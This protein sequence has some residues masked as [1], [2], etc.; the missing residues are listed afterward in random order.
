MSRVLEKLWY[1]GGKPSWPWRSLLSVGEQLYGAGVAARNGL[2]DRGWMPAARPQGTH[3]VSVGNLHAGGMGKTPVVWFLASLLSAQ[4]RKV[5]ILTRGYGRASKDDQVFDAR[6]LP[7]VERVGDEPRLLAQRLPDARIYV[8]ADRRALAFRAQEEGAEVLLLDDGFQHRRLGRD[9][10][11][12]VADEAVGFGQGALLPKGPLREPVHALKRA[13]LVWW[14]AAEGEPAELPQGI[15]LPMVRARR[16]VD[17]LLSPHGA[18]EPPVALAGQA[19]WLVAGI[20]R[21]ERFERTVR[22][23][24]ADVRGTSWF[25]DHHHFSTAELER[26][27]AEARRAEAWLVTTEKD[28]QRLPP[29]LVVVV[30]EG[31]ELLE[32]EAALQAVL[33]Q[34]GL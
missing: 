30:R 21:P 5:A 23:L 19:V 20:A 28:A 11:V 7:T 32:G 8:G 29:E 33:T 3:I 34:A 18:I 27:V 31:V 14:F 10:D 16:V 12:V 25:A 6:A 13:H 4:G 24:G 1:G 9:I 22:G 2:F 15:T 26:V 17:S